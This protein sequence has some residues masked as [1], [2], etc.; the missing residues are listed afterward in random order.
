[1][2]VHRRAVFDCQ[3]C[4][5]HV[6]SYYDAGVGERCSTCCWVRD[7]VAPEHHEAVRKRLGVPVR[8]A[9]P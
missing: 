9:A 4:G 3:D 2:T 8:K 5:Q 1:M 7:Y 6:V